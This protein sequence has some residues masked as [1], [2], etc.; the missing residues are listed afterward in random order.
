MRRARRRLSSLVILTAVAGLVAA[1]MATATFATSTPT[2]KSAAAEPSHSPPPKPKPP[3]DQESTS[4]S[5]EPPPPPPPPPDPLLPPDTA[6]SNPVTQ[7]GKKEATL[8]LAQLRTV[9]V[10]TASFLATASLRQT[11]LPAIP[12]TR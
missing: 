2:A 11:A 4:E 3:P 10:G 7:E 9:L 6:P 1:G 12:P 8:T 5:E